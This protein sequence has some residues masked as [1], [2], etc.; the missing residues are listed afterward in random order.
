MSAGRGLFL[1]DSVRFV[2]GVG[3]QRALLLS[4]LGIETV[5]DLLDHFP[6]RIDDF[7][8]VTAMGDIHPG[9]EVT[10]QG[11]VTSTRF[12]GSRRGRALRVD[13]SDGT[14]LVHLVWYNM[15]YMYQHFHSG[16][17]IVAS[18]Q[19]SWR[20][21][22]LE[23]AHPIWFA[24]EE[25][26][27]NGPVI[28]V[29]HASASF[30]S[31][32]IHKIVGQALSQCFD[33]IRGDMPQA[34]LERYGYMEEREAYRTIHLPT[35][36]DLWHRARRTFAFR[37]MLYLQLGLMSMRQ[38]ARRVNGPKVFS[39]LGL[40]D[41]FIRDLPFKLTGAQE[42][43]IADVKNDVFGTSVMNRLLQGDVGSGKTVVAIYALLAA[44]AN[45]YQGA[46][47][48]PTEV[49]AK[50]HKRT[51]ESLCKD[52]CIFGFLS[53]GVGAK[54]KAETLAKLRDGRIQVLIG[55]HAMLEPG[56]SWANLG[57]VVTD[58]QHRFGVRQR[59][60]LPE[61]NATFSAHLLVM[62]ATP[63]PRSLALTLF[64][65]LD[66][67]VID[68]LPP[69]RRPVHTQVL[70]DRQRS[71]AYEK[72][73][74]EVGKGHQAY[75]VC[76]VISEGKTDRKAASDVFSELARGFLKGT[77]LGLVHG[78][79]PKA[80]VEQVMGE[81]VNGKIDVLVSTTV[82]EVGIDVPNATCMVVEDA[83][84]F[85]LA[86][87]HQLRG[88]VGRGS[89]KSHCFLIS[90]AGGDARLRLRLLEKHHDGFQVA[91]MDLQNRGPGQFFG[92][93][94]HGASET[95]F[96]DLS[97]SLDEIQRARDEARR[98]VHCPA[99]DEERSLVAKVKKRFG[100]L[101][102]AGMSR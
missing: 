30:T 75:V 80:E 1:D 21:G 71:V 19:A 36:P 32:A 96:S 94:Q 100:N 22:G 65:D 12:V 31:Q 99:D 25:P 15:P 24:S 39:D 84:S 34:I 8:N 58:E 68:A 86:S 4:G 64:G 88:R 6:F 48:A 57:L 44:V 82:I 67:T 11:L 98:I 46:L 16:R 92:L 18:G 85:G 66:I 40:A 37:E 51:F 53:G 91:E 81:F 90:K 26:V 101:A 62:S 42:R 72:V 5:R 70:H 56:V 33:E 20:R 60:S 73:M 97:L 93:R 3:P 7:S 89:S 14:G 9:D 49:L 69:G 54:E 47:L 2:K 43:A 55:T 59:L 38:E 27:Q 41:D 83:E 74:E 52:R 17:M 63:I 77:R 76:P 78:S 10:V 13:L 95:R 79:M 61:A 50:Q 102:A 87:L 23:M 29:Y 28:P 35:N 45:G